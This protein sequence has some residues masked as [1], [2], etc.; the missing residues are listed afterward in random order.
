M[1]RLVE[2]C[3]A[4]LPLGHRNLRIYLRKLMAHIDWSSNQGACMGLT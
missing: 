3:E 4:G 1:L 2:L